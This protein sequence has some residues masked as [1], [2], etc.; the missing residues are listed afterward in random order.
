MDDY[1]FS[2]ASASIRHIQYILGLLSLTL[3]HHENEGTGSQRGPDVGLFFVFNFEQEGRISAASS[4][5]S[6][7]TKNMI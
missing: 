1:S 2:E 5:K 7:F 3:H 6:V 4:I